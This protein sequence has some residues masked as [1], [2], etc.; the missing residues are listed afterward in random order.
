MGKIKKKCICMVLTIILLFGSTTTYIQ[1]KTPDLL[2][3]D[4]VL[5]LDVS[6]SMITADPNRLANEAMNMFIDMLEKERDRV[7]VVAYAGHI[8]Y[9]RELTLLNEDNL[10]Y[11][12][13]SISLLEYASWTDHPLGLLE[14][15]RIMYDGH[16]KDRQPII[17]FLTDGNFNI[18][19]H[20]ARTVAQA[21]YDKIL[22][23]S[24]AQEHGFPIYS[25]GLNFDGALDRRYI[26][27]VA[28]ATGGLSFETAHAEDLPEILNAIFYLMIH[29]PL[30]LE[31]LQE[32]PE[33]APTQASYDVYQIP[34][35]P[36]EPPYI[37]QEPP[38]YENSSPM[39]IAAF[40]SIVAL[41]VLAFVLIRRAKRVFTGHLVINVTDTDSRKANPTQYRNL[42]EYGSRV[43][44]QTLIG[45]DTSPELSSV[46]LTPSPHAPSHLPQLMIKCRNPQIKFMKNFMEQRASDG[47]G[48]SAGTEIIILPECDKKQIRI[49]Y[50]V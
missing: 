14:A 22:A 8:T 35:T 18:S 36:E 50:N 16:T 27:I 9:S 5:V 48:I 1:A 40:I 10:S 47:I 43:T 38:Y 34:Y 17:I 15:I 41:V 25:I 19:P 12:Q 20:G 30:P 11:L 21:D 3:I 23:I 49:I 29:A 31:E 37:P 24:L 26:D 46:I 33:Y 2:P 28:D 42:I 7:G 4:A 44:L 39:W 13:N 6:L 45:R 32:E